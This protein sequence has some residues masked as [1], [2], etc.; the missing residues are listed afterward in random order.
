M[1]DASSLHRL[2][3]HRANQYEIA[4][5]AIG[6]TCQHYNRSKCFNSYGFGAKIPPDYKVHYNFPLNLDTNDPRCYGVEALLQS[7]LVAQSK[8]ELSGPTDF[9]PTIRFAARRAASLPE[10]GAKYCVL[11]IITDGV[12]TDMDSYVPN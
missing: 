2:D 10:N 3:S 4:I 1:D 5:E 8:V 12:I 7:Y 9:T 11:L 6:E